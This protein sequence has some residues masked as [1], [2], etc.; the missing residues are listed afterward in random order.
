M[1]VVVN[2][3]AF[4]LGESATVLDAVAATGKRPDNSR[5][6][7]VAVNGEVIPR[8]EWSAT[9]LAD[10]DKVEVLTAVAGG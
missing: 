3:S 4:D 8:G 2:G 1:T 5:G 10:G 7:A 6:V 9:S